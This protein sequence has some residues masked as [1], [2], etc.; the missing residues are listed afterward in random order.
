MDN[1]D[2]IAAPITPEGTGAVGVIRISGADTFRI[3]DE[4]FSGKKP[5]EAKSHSILFG[6]IKDGKEII[7]EVLVSIFKNPASYTGEDIAEISCHGSP[8]IMKRLLELI[9]RKGARIAQPGEFTFRAFMNGKMDLAQSE[10]VADLIASQSGA[11]HKIALQQLRGDFSN[12]I[13]QLREELIKFASLLELE[14]DFSEEDVEFA[15]RDQ[16][17]KLLR[18]IKEIILSLMASFEY[19]NAIKNGVATVIAGRPNAGKSTLL[20]AILQE[21]RAIVSEIAGTTRDTIEEQIN[22]KGILFRFVDTAGIRDTTDKIEK[23]GVER[24]L[25]KVELANICIYLFDLSTSTEEDVLKDISLLKKNTETPLILVG[26]KKDL[27]ADNKLLKPKVSHEVLYISKTEKE[28]VEALKE[29][30]YQQVAAM[31]REAGSHILSNVRHYEALAK[32]GEAI[33]AS[34]EGL[35]E[36][37]SGELVAFDIKSALNNLGEITGSVST[38]DLLE[39]IFRNF[40]IGK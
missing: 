34:I 36:D 5:T 19:G 39:N 31:K 15:D 14:L 25:K 11:S 23:Q 9:V 28:S 3:V 26:S 40:C 22:I 29:H 38:D 32:A 16:L 18:E 24:A 37:R 20:N 7:D 17:V 12:Q 4:I 13:T 33:D 35:L 8:Y 10:A 2:T 30:L 6:L 1:T 21:E 27:V